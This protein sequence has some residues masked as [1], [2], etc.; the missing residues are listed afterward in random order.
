MGVAVVG[1][2][3]PALIQRVLETA[4]G[5][6]PK[7]TSDKANVDKPRS[8]PVAGAKHGR[9]RL[10]VDRP[11]AAQSSIAIGWPGARASDLDL[12]TLEVLAGATGGDISTRL[13]LTVRKE[14]GAS[15][16]VHMR[17]I[18]LRDAG[19]VTITA[20]T[21]TARTVDAL[22]G[23]FREIERLRVE[24]LSAAELFGAKLR[25]YDELEHGSTRGL[26]RQLGRAISEDRPAAA[27]LARSARVDL[28][29][30][31][32][33]RA[34][35]QRYLAMDDVRVVVVGDAAKLADGLRT[36]GPFEVSVVHP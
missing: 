3:K 10:V 21:D 7:S 11:G 8:G 12:V 16:G 31:E 4:L 13:N 1:D 28:V 19:L 35:A 22:R 14:L 30:A 33:V 20:A 24:P 17:A 23:M 27:V 9:T 18:G 26:A 34:A 36:L 2:F 29:T 15:Y 25:T 32:N 5:K 6:L